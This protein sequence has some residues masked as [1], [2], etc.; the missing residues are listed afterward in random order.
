R[1]GSLGGQKWRSLAGRRGAAE[2]DGN[3]VAIATSPA[4]SSS[5]EWDMALHPLLK[6]IDV[7][8]L[9][10]ITGDRPGFQLR[11]PG[12]STLANFASKKLAMLSYCFLIQ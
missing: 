7:L 12:S 1:W 6:C 11:E 5:F 8:L 10:R 2:T 9:L 4:R 3:A